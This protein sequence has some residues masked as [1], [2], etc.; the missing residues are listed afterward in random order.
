MTHT[1]RMYSKCVVHLAIIQLYGGIPLVN[2]FQI[3]RNTMQ[4]NGLM[5]ELLS[6]QVSTLA[7]AFFDLK[8][9]ESTL[10]LFI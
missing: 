3:A 9:L 4:M 6:T 10:Y 2:C 1:Y 7:T 5:S 8:I